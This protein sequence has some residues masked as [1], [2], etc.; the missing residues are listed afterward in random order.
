[1][2]HFGG[3]GGL[4]G[5][6]VAGRAHD[7]AG[8][9]GSFSPQGVWLADAGIGSRAT[10]A[11]Q[12]RQTEVRD[13]HAAAAVQEDVL[14]LDVPVNDATVVGV[15][16]GVTKLGHD[17]QRL[18]RGDAAAREELAQV[19][20]VHELHEDEKQPVV[21]AAEI[22]NG[23]DAGMVEL[24]EGA[25]LAGETVGEGGIVAEG[26]G[27]D[28]QRD[29]A[30]ELALARAID[31]AHA[32]AP[33]DLENLQLRELARQLGGGRRGE[34]V[35]AG[36]VAGLRGGVE[37]AGEQAGRAQPL[38]GGGQRRAAL[39]ARRAGRS[40][41]CWGGRSG[42]VPVLGKRG[43]L[44]QVAGGG[45]EKSAGGERL[46]EVAQLGLDFGWRVHGLRDLVAEQLAV[47]AAQ[48]VDGHAGG[49]FAEA[50]GAGGVGVAEVFAVG[51]EEGFQGREL[52]GTA[53]V[54]ELGLEPANRAVEQGQR[55]LAVVEAVGGKRGGGERLIL[56]FERVE[57]DGRLRA[58]A[59]EGA[60]AVPFVREE[61]LEGGE[62]KGAETAFAR[63][64]T[65]N[66]ALLQQPGEKSLRE[67]L[68]IV[69]GMAAPAH[70][71]VERW[72]VGAA[73][74]GERLVG[75]RGVAV[76]GMEHER[77]MGGGE[78]G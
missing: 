30:V 60:G 41:G 10:F 56:G 78:P 19:H 39:R 13:L 77:P 25:G 46:H 55:P 37:I 73:Q 61:A 64:G 76:A 35:P 70:I 57:R 28:F 72:P 18:A 6:H 9:G 5:G 27:E 71:G 44:L 17:G 14:G 34:G 15:L 23:D 2:I 59:L 31:R 47:A 51:G 48:A 54:G 63:V 7:F 20:A 3:V 42:H 75:E 68:R 33:D 40:R 26:A 22:V 67:V 52:G 65:L 38:H 69:D 1:V 12:L 43:G 32:A 49:A 11:D 4:L 36:G 53:G 8:L 21:R 45:A 24:G 62:Q 50:G 16:Q 29:E 58:A 66:P 74:G